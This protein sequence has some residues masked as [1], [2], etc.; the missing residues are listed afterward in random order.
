MGILGWCS[1]TTGSL[2]PWATEQEEFLA[3]SQF[4]NSLRQSE[5]DSPSDGTEFLHL[6]A[7]MFRVQLRDSAPQDSLVGEVRDDPIRSFG[8][9]PSFCGHRCVFRLRLPRL[10]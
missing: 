1:G 3:Q 6:G 7:R 2:G 4:P 5:L 9:Q 10:G 8:L